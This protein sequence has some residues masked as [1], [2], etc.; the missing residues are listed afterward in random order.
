MNPDVIMCYILCFNI[1]FLFS[2][3]ALLRINDDDDYY[4][5][6]TVSSQI[7]NSK[8]LLIKYRFVSLWC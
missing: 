3:Y 6:K 2:S 5:Y 7:M 1:L 8:Y 4:Y